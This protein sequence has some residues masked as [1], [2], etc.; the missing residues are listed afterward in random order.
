MSTEVN[1]SY[2]YSIVNLKA[3]NRSMPNV[4]AIASVKIT[5]H[6]F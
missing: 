3:K 1:T 4:F 2:V 6:T 5:N